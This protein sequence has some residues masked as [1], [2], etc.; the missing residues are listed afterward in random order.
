VNL[1]PQ[2]SGPGV[3]D[4]LH[5]VLGIC[6]RV[7]RMLGADCCFLYGLSSSCF[8]TSVLLAA[9]RGFSSG[10]CESLRET[11]YRK[12]GRP[13]SSGPSYEECRGVIT[14]NAKRVLSSRMPRL[15]VATKVSTTSLINHIFILDKIQEFMHYSPSRD[16]SRCGVHVVCVVLGPLTLLPTSERSSE[17]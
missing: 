14:D 12:T 11:F 3:S 4:A 17:K 2:L 1:L 9:K 10:A 5:L 6:A 16:Q 8:A 15:W 13:P 7:D